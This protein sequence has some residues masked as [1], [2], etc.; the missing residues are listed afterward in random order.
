[1]SAYTRHD[2]V[3]HLCD[4]RYVLARDLIWELGRK[5]SGFEYV[6]PAG[7]VFDVSVP[8]VLRWLFS[9]HDMR[10]LKAAALHD[11][12]LENGWNRVE[13]AGP[14]ERALAADGTPL[15][16][17]LLMFLAVALYQYR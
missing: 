17:R 1:M 16:R 5:G 2:D 9:P 14:F 8:P 11:H 10:F 3:Y 12:M 15:W 4:A 13:A 6:V 7:F